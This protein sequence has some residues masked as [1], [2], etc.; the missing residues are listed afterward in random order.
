MQIL[1]WAEFE[2]VTVNTSAKN[3]LQYKQYVQVW[4]RSCCIPTCEHSMGEAT[5]SVKCDSYK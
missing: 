1:F 5:T 2:P 4:V 3:T